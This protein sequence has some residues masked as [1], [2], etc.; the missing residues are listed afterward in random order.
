MRGIILIVGICLGACGVQAQVLKT[1]VKHPSAFTSS[2]FFVGHSLTQTTYTLNEG[3]MMAGTFA[4]AFGVTDSITL[5]TSPWLLG[6]YNMPN[7]IVRTKLDLMKDLALGVQ[8]GYMRTEPYLQDQYKMEASYFNAL[9]SK[10][11]SRNFTTHLQLNVMNFSDDERPFSL[12]VENPTT[13]LQISVSALS[14]ISI[15]KKYKDEFGLGLEVGRIGINEILPYN[16]VG[17]S[18]FRKVGSL[19]IQGGVSISATPNVVLNDLTYIGRS[20]LPAGPEFKKIVTHPEVQLQWF[21]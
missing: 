12:R 5:A 16:H 3:Q 17:L 11:W 19:L 15:F 14:E 2:N 6:L 1:K 18:L 21:F 8:G 4:M 7:V 9:V 13:P 20:N 10:K